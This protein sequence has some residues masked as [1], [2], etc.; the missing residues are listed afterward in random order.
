MLD[1]LDDDVGC[2][3]LGWI[4]HEMWMVVESCRGGRRL[5]AALEAD[6]AAL[7]RLRRTAYSAKFWADNAATWRA[8][9][10]CRQ[11]LGPRLN[12]QRIARWEALVHRYN[13]D[14]A[15]EELTDASYLER[16]QAE[17]AAY[18]ITI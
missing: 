7:I 16:W 15:A 5:V 1:R 12:L 4:R 2:W 11:D 9:M 8:D 6:E 3:V 13:G 10:S 17:V 18:N 14:G